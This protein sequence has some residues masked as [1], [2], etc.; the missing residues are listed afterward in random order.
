MTPGDKNSLPTSFPGNGHWKSGRLKKND[1]ENSSLLKYAQICTSMAVLWGE[2]SVRQI[3]LFPITSLD[4]SLMRK[5]KS[6]VNSHQFLFLG[7]S[8]HFL[9]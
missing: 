6:T 9:V 4:V 2:G 7:V 5:I 3:D 8:S 1:T